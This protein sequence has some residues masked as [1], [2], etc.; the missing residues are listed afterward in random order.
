MATLNKEATTQGIRQYHIHVKPGEIGKYV[1]LP[2]DPARS[3]RV[4]KYLKDPQLVA[5]N[6]EH[7]T[8]TGLYNGVRVSVTSTGM[9]CPSTAIAAE[10][11]I[12]VGA[13]CL[14]RIGSTAALQP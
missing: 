9:G 5:N 4:A 6:R 2:G 8:I 3:D 10:E 13:E 12:N 14:I 7:R 1:L 11:L